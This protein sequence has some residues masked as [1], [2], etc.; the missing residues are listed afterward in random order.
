MK[1]R[2][3]LLLTLVIVVVLAGGFGLGYRLHAQ[4][5]YKLKPTDVLTVREDQLAQERLAGKIN[6]LIADYNAATE[7]L[8][9]DSTTALQNAGA[10]PK[11][12]QIAEDKGQ[13][14][15][16]LKPVEPKK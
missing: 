13:L 11:T 1:S 9:A 15:I 12:H 4:K 5:V 16:R 10:D 8:N 7:K 14:I 2:A 6:P 3:N